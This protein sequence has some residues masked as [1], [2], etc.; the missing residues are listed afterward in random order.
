MLP[1]KSSDRSLSLASFALAF[2]LSEDALLLPLRIPLK[3]SVQVALQARL[4]DG[5]AGPS[6]ASKPPPPQAAPI[7]SPQLCAAPASCF[8]S[9]IGT[10]P[11]PPLPSFP[12][13][14]SERNE[15]LRASPS[16][17]AEHGAGCEAKAFCKAV[18][19]DG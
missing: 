10:F 5:S 1:K 6:E 4:E 14:L 15:H 3:A 18:F 2:S 11:A 7:S 12:L 8:K 19:P 13:P 9:F 16:S 17:T